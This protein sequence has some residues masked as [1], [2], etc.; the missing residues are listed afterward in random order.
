LWCVAVETERPEEGGGFSVWRGSIGDLDAC[1]GPVGVVVKEDVY[2]LSVP[3]VDDDRRGVWAEEFAGRLFWRE[4]WRIRLDEFLELLVIASCQ[5]QEDRIG[6][7]ADDV[8]RCD[9]RFGVFGII[10]SG[11]CGRTKLGGARGQQGRQK[12][13]NK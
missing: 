4:A 10:W 13:G 1:G 12:E 8:P 9:E 7:M 2:F 11:W 3:A 6:K 5:R